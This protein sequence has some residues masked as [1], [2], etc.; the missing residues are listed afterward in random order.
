MGGCRWTC[1]WEN[2]QFFYSNWSQGFS[3]FETMCKGS[4]LWSSSNYYI[5]FFN[6]K[7]YC[8]IYIC[9][10]ITIYP[11]VLYVLFLFY[12]SCL[13]VIKMFYSLLRLMIPEHMLPNTNHPSTLSILQC[14]NHTVIN[15]LV[16]LVIAQI[17]AYTALDILFQ[18]FFTALLKRHEL[19]DFFSFLYWF[20]FPFFTKHCFGV[21]MKLF[22]FIF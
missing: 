6:P 14:E 9:L 2:A 17:V 22:Y 12:I 21:G 8:L 15:V 11:F 4:K 18:D 13:I 7:V 1:Y 20:F 19:L 5:W 16:D 3:S 10:P